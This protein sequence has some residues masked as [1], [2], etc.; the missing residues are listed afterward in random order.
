MYLL[1]HH[2]QISL[3]LFQ[4]FLQRQGNPDWI[5][6]TFCQN[7]NTS[8]RTHDRADPLL[9]IFFYAPILQ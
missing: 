9:G 7:V 8:V 6:G 1:A 2:H 5:N 4:H 3:F